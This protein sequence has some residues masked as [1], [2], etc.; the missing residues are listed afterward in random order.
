MAR[1][2][3]KMKVDLDL[4]KDDST[5]TKLYSILA[6]SI[7]MG[8]G[9]LG[10]WIINTDFLE[11]PN[12]QPIFT[13]TYCGYNPQFD[14]TYSLNESC[15][16]PLG[17]ILKDEANPAVWEPLENWRGVSA[18]AQDFSVPGMSD[19]ELG[20]FPRSERPQRMVVSC[21]AV[22]SNPIGYSV[23]IRGDNDTLLAWDV[24]RTPTQEELLADPGLN[25]GQ[26]YI[27][28]SYSRMNSNATVSGDKCNIDIPDVPPGDEYSIAVFAEDET[29]S[30]FSFQI[31]IYAYDG[32]PENMNNKS[33]W[34][35]P[36]VAALGGIHPT[37]FLNFFGFGLF[38]MFYPASLFWDKQMKAL[39]D[40]EEKFPDFLRDLAEYWK[41]GLAMT[42]AVQ[43]LANSEYGALNPEV[44][45]MSDQISWGI[46]F[47]IVLLQFSDRVGT[48]LVKRAISLINE[49][50]RAGG[51]ISDILVTAANDSREIKFLEG[52]RARA[53]ASYIAVIWVSYFVFLGVIIVLSKVFIPAIA[54][55]NSG[56]SGDEGG[57]SIG[58]MEIRAIDPLFFLT[59]FYY[60]VTMQ[61]I[62][63]GTMA[64]LM[65]TGRFTSG[66]K[67]AGM[68]IVIGLLA[69]NFVAYSPDLI[70]IPEPLPLNPALGSYVPSKGVIP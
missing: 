40:V 30:E 41:G 63:N 58:N 65:A 48:P 27:F 31:T 9:C 26:T 49:A 57:A 47:E 2:K 60:G 28:P 16:G 38:L 29:L 45:K 43:T 69:F 54:S 68:M 5:M 20:A 19:E 59:V 33:L 62:G 70:G 3:A 67:H 13:N 18:R 24:E 15:D 7:M 14:P 55:S 46:S 8:L 56:E 34:V 37:I 64:G 42:V 50:N 35:G 23:E 6:V 22:A 39:N 21:E 12:G 36:E 66:L 1:K 10:F 44:K 4:P 11:T 53:I 25:A 17:K 61:G 52:E 32:I 51:K